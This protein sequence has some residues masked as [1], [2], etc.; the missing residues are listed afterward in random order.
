MASF[1]DSTT[2]AK[3][4]AQEE[5]WIL[6]FIFI[7]HGIISVLGILGNVLV[8]K[9][10]VSNRRRKVSDYLIVN[11]CATDLGA[12]IVSIPLDLVERAWKSFPFGAFLCKIVY[13]FQT[14]L[15]AASVMTLLAM[16]Y[17]RYRMIVTPFKRHITSRAAIGT[18]IVAW[19]ISILL[20]VPYMLVLQLEEDQCLENWSLDIH[21]KAF[22]LSMFILLYAIPMFLITVFYTLIVRNLYQDSKRQVIECYSISSDRSER[23]IAMM[24][25]RV[26]RNMRVVKVFMVAGI[27][28]A[29]CML[30]THV[31]WLWHDYGSGSTNAHFTKIV[32]FTNVL[33][34]LNSAIDPFIFGSLKLQRLFLDVICCRVCRDADRD[35]FTL[36]TANKTIEESATDNEAVRKISQSSARKISQ[37]SNR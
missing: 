29:V 31:C 30:P 21:R 27:V 11:L 34:Y 33:M 36:R 12:C 9:A 26:Q 5:S 37:I 13:P 23:R 14:I 4:N 16:S 1:N 7:S 18:I 35:F 6:A 25:A 15:M 3:G 28:F 2:E 24:I 17:E 22:T 19:V 32:T 20:V 8:L 10:I